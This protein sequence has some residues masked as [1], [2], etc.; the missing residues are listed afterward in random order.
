MKPTN[1]TTPWFING[2]RPAYEGVYNVSCRK[3]N[4]TG[5]WYGYWTGTGFKPWA[6]SINKA[7]ENAERYK[8]EYPCLESSWCGLDENPSK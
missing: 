3:E 5:D 7:Y 1:K 4:Q 6:L 8:D 2:E